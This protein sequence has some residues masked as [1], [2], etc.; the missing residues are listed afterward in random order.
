[1]F[2]MVVAF[3]A[4]VAN[5]PLRL[6]TALG[7]AVTAAVIY[8]IWF[9]WEW[10]A[11]IGWQALVDYINPDPGDTTGKKDAIQV[12]AV[13]L[14]GAIASVTAAVG[15]ANLRLTRKNLEQQRELETQRAEQQRELA[16]GTALQA[17]YEQIGKLLTEYDLRNT[18]RE[19]IR[20]LARG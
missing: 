14:A 15:L 9:D 11:M 8:G 3:R 6:V 7:L 2:R 1:M 17:Y 20:E 18:Q 16:Q 4:A 19:E 5:K 13:I 10:K 12:Y